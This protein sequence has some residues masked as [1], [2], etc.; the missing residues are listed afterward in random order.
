MQAL[1]TGPGR[2]S[3]SAVSCLP[4]HRRVA[5]GCAVTPRAYRGPVKPR[6]RLWGR[7]GQAWWPLSLS[8]PGRFGEAAT[9][10][11]ARQRGLRSDTERGQNDSKQRG[12]RHGA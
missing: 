8:F 9:S 7:W 3:V 2:S 1:M 6:S 5:V 12:L 4:Y 11:A 10:C